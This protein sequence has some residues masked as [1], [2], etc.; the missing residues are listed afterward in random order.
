MKTQRIIFI[1]AAVAVSFYSCSEST[2]GAAGTDNAEAVARRLFML[3]EDLRSAEDSALLWKLATIAYEGCEVR[4]GRI[5][6]LI[7]RKKFRENG[8]TE[9]YYDILKK[10]IEGLN[11]FLDTTS[12]PKQLLLDS[13][14][15]A[16]EQYL[17]EQEKR[18]RN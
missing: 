9:I 8:V 16:R 10:D 17:A 2:K 5:E 11:N 13:W 18:R 1:L 15:E 14:Q 12:G 4:D 7:T 3:P 6:I